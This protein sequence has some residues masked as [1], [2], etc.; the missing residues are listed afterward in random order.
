[1]Q[2]QQIIIGSFLSGAIKFFIT[3]DGL[4]RV[5]SHVM[6]HPDYLIILTSYRIIF[7][8]GKTIWLFMSDPRYCD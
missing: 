7:P 6:T 4:R 5:Q 1:M 3:S 2:G 8:A